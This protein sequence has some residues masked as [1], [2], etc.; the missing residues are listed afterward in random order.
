MSVDCAAPVDGRREKKTMEEFCEQLQYKLEDYCIDFYDQLD[1]AR[2]EY[3]IVDEEGNSVGHKVDWGA[4]NA[5]PLI[6]ISYIG[7]LLTP[8]ERVINDFEKEINYCK[9]TINS[10]WVKVRDG[11]CINR[12]CN[13]VEGID[14]DAFGRNLY[15]SISSFTRVEN[16]VMTAYNQISDLD[17]SVEERRELHQKV[18]DLFAS[19][20]TFINKG[21][22]K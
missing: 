6:D 18:N 16:A 20:K 2:E 17:I 19:L 15:W 14:F 22:E 1:E 13:Q 4:F 5:S 9:D 8:Q 10:F 12:G 11:K 21:E 7:E 3:E